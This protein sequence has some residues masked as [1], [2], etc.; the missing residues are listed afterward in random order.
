MSKKH[1]KSKTFRILGLL[2]FHAIAIDLMK[3]AEQL[4]LEYQIATDLSDLL[5]EERR[6]LLRAKK[7]A[8]NA[9]AP[10]SQFRVGAALEWEDGT[11]FEG[12]NHE[13]AVFPAGACAE[14]V[15]LFAASAHR[16]GLRINRL[17]ISVAKEKVN[18]PVPPCGIC[19]QVI[20]EQENKQQS[21]IQLILQGYT[22]DIYLLPSI[23][24]LL[25]LRFD[26]DFL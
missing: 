11:Y 18:K 3:R 16:P 12:A 24:P 19:R 14:Q 22:G 1:I 6:L 21:P 13:N 23:K 5:P 17:A 7:A 25:P 9:Y 8:Q 2:Y 4:Q 20:L 15:A 26:A 10:Y